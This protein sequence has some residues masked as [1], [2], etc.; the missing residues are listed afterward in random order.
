MPYIRKERRSQIDPTC[1]IEYVLPART[2]GELNFQFTMLA[3]Q[4]FKLNGSN[5]QAINDIIGALE[6]CKMEFYERIARPY[7]DK[8]IQE[9]SDVY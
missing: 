5:Y 6:G 4:Y 8:K 2:S 7:E 9:N 3:K 1:D